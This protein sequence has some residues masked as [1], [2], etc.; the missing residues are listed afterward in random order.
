MMEMYPASPPLRVQ[1]SWGFGR[2]HEDDD[3]DSPRRRNGNRKRRPQ[4]GIGIHPATYRALV[5]S[6]EGE[7][8][9]RHGK[10]RAGHGDGE[11]DGVEKDL[12]LPPATAALD[13]NIARLLAAGR[14]ATLWLDDSSSSSGPERGARVHICMQ[15]SVVF[16]PHEYLIFTL[17]TCPFFSSSPH[18]YFLSWKSYRRKAPAATSST[19]KWR[20]WCGYPPPLRKR[21][22]QSRS[23][24]QGLATA[25]WRQAIRLCSPPDPLFISGTGL[26]SSLLSVHSAIS[27]YI[28]TFSF[29][30]PS[31]LSLGDRYKTSILCLFAF[32]LAL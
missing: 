8:G 5:G 2:Q 32:V 10:Q 28:D 31:L 30:P 20:C 29:P 1:P 26:Y 14:L 18:L 6:K 24:Q 17:L 25:G 22:A 3:D 19:P 27:K 15:T 13:G 11:G 21:P 16:F 7:G 12:V 9:G 4:T 23:D